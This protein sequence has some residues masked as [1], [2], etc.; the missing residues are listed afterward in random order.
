MGYFD[1][2]YFSPAYFDTGAGVAS[3]ASR[4]SLRFVPFPTPPTPNEEDDEIA[5]RLL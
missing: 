2:A 5:V 3:G 4:K 1:A